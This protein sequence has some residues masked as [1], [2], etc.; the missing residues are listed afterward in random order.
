MGRVSGQRRRSG[1]LS[2]TCAPTLPTHAG[3]RAWLAPGYLR[4][5]VLWSRQWGPPQRFGL[6]NF[7]CAFAQFCS[8]AEL[9]LIFSCR[10][11]CFFVLSSSVKFGSSM[12]KGM[13]P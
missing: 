7:T 6:A 10:I 11:R 12:V 13:T 2:L 4:K 8:D 3:G 9:S 1:S 5:V